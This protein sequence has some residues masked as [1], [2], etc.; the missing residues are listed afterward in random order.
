MTS[1]GLDVPAAIAPPAD[2]GAGGAPGSAAAAAVA[3]AVVRPLRPCG[4]VLAP[5]TRRAAIG[6][7]PLARRRRRLLLRE[8]R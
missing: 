5:R 3:P 4:P 7:A 2:G 6:R 1:T 8:A